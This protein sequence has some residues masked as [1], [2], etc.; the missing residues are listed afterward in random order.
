[1]RLQ[2]NM[3][4]VIFVSSYI[5]VFCENTVMHPIHFNYLNAYII[6]FAILVNFTWRIL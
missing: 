4:V 2:P 5:G 3:L 1:M 6:T